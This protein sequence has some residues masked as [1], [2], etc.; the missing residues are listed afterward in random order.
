MSIE[1]GGTSAGTPAG[2]EMTLVGELTGDRACAACGFNLVGQQIVREPHYGMLM[3]R[4]PECSAAAALQEYPSLG[5]WAGRLTT[6]AAAVFIAAVLGLYCVTS[7]MIGGFSSEFDARGSMMLGRE[8]A[9]MHKDY[10]MQRQATPGAAGAGMPFS[11]AQLTGWEYDQIERAW[12]D[13]VDK[14]ALREKAVGFWAQMDRVSMTGLAGMAAL[15]LGAGMCWSV[16]LCAVRRRRVWMFAVVVG[17]GAGVFLTFVQRFD[18]YGSF[19]TTTYAIELAK[20]LMGVL[21]S[22]QVLGFTLVLLATGLMV[23]RSIARWVVACL[24]TPRHRGLFAFL[25]NCDG[26]KVP[27]TGDGRAEK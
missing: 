20:S 11:P 10:Q 9:A 12:W 8:I 13:G 17:L 26:L 24:L 4:C 27:R 23:G 1:Q 16:V 18:Q 6:L 21:P 22:W 3:V 2:G 5:R 19:G 7:I 15:G 25:W 14:T